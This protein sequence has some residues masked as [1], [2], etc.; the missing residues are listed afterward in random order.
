[1]LASFDTIHTHTQHGTQHISSLSFFLFSTVDIHPPVGFGAVFGLKATVTERREIWI[2]GLVGWVGGAGLGYLSRGSDW[3]SGLGGGVNTIVVYLCL[4]VGSSRGGFALM[5]GR[6]L[7][8]RQRVG[9]GL[10]GW[11]SSSAVGWLAAFG[12]FV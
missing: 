12:G 11:L 5:G 2:Q 9:V 8:G 3:E 4:F 10:A 6:V 1:L 7:D